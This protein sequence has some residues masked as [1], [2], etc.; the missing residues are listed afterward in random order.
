MSS[1]SLYALYASI[2]FII[3]K[4]HEGGSIISPQFASEET[5]AR[6]ENS[7][8]PFTRLVDGIIGALT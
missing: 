5:E 6:Q 8:A 3:S 2:H 1:S 4:P 7:L